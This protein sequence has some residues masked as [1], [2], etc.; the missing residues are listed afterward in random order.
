MKEDHQLEVDTPRPPQVMDASRPPEPDSETA[1]LNEIKSE[2][3]ETENP[4]QG[5]PKSAE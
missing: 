5:R 2:E 3:A 4:K 1:T